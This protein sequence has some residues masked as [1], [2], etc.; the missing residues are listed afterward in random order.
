MILKQ[1]FKKWNGKAWTGLI[2]LKMGTSG[3]CKCGNEPLGFTKCRTF[4]DWLRTCFS[5]RTLLH[6]VGWLV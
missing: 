3:G 2:W 5:R 6:A 1:V 4:L